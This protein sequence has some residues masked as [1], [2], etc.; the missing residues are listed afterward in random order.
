MNTLLA[1][2]V[3]AGPWV[4]S[5]DFPQAKQEAA[6]NATLRLIVATP[7]TRGEGT[8][9]RIGHLGPWVYYLTANHI[10]AKFQEVDLESF[11]AKSIPNPIVTIEKAEVERR[12]PEIDLAILKA[13]EPDPPGFLPI[14]KDVQSD[15]FPI[16]VLTVGCSYGNEPVVVIDKVVGQLKIRK[17]DRTVGLYWEAQLKPAR[18]RSGGPLV[19]S[20]GELIGICS[21]TDGDK[22][23]K[24]YYV[25]WEEITKALKHSKYDQLLAQPAKPANS[26][27]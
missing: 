1:A 14:A 24:G 12:W 13:R 8:A 22:I 27:K 7:L 2:I 4:Q 17:P 23:D 18:G 15:K 16:S 9:V 10:V 26:E 19:N 25:H 6:L 21:G 5:S 11:S 20:K 3:F